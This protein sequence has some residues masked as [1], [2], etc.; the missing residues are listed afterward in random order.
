MGR[1][2]TRN[3]DLP[4]GVLSDSGMTFSFRAALFTVLVFPLAAWAAP[5]TAVSADAA[6]LGFDPARL[7]R[8]DAVIQD[9]VDRRQ[10]AGGIMYIA[11]DGRIAHRRTFGMQD[12][13]AARPMSPAC[14]G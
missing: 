11:R 10:I 9:H 1:R 7:Q 2:R 5:A 12:I 13:E 6:E 14:R 4:P 8:L 3:R